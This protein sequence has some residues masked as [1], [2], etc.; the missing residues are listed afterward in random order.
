MHNPCVCVCI[1]TRC[2]ARPGRCLQACAGRSDGWIC[3]SSRSYTHACPSTSQVLT[4]AG[5]LNKN[6]WVLFAYTL[7][8]IKDGDR[9]TAS[10]GICISPPLSSANSVCIPLTQ[11]FA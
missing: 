7:S 9:V 6:I 4:F 1:R 5:E 10:A 3:A 11:D 2:L 8:I